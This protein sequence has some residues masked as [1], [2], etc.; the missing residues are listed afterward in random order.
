MNLLTKVTWIIQV[1]MQAPARSGSSIFNYK[2][3]HSIVLMAI[4]N[5]RYQFTIVD[6]GDSGRQRDGSV[7]ASSN[8]GYAIQ[9][10]QL[11]LPREKK[12]RNF[13]R[14]LPHVLVGDDAFWLKPH[15]MKPYPSQ[16]LPT[17]QRVFNYR[18]SHTRRIIE[19]VFGICAS[20]F[21]VLRRPIIASP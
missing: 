18:L 13:Q 19:N 9:N 12:L 1:V 21:R 5:A 3:T 20:R 6:I 15:L 17:D 14:I 11:K 4:R 7:Y 10:K 16:N 2:K 8:L